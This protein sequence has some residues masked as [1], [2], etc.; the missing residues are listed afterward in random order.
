MLVDCIRHQLL[1]SLN[2]VLFKN[3]LMIIVIKSDRND[4]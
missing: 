1:C 2:A 3:I 4:P